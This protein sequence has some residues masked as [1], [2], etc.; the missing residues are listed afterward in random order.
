MRELEE[1]TRIENIKLVDGFQ[2]EINYDFNVKIKGGVKE[3]IYKEVIFF[4]GEAD[5]Q[6]IKISKEHLDFGWFDYQ[7]AAKRLFYQQGQDLLKKAHQ[8]L[9]KQQDF[10]L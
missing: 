8:F 2:G 4:L 3:K 5:S 6:K 7:T 1:K 9:L 10:V